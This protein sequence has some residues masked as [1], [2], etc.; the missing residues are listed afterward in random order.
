MSKKRRIVFVLF[1]VVLVLLVCIWF[2]TGNTAEK[3]GHGAIFVERGKQYGQIC[4]YTED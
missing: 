4:L 2:L 1:A 3:E